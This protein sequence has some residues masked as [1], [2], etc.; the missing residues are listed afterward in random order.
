[1]FCHT[2][3]LNGFAS[4]RALINIH[5]YYYYK[6]V[7]IC[8][9]IDIFTSHSLDESLSNYFIYSATDGENSCAMALKFCRN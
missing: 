3:P 6:A 8:V 7:Y 1:M 2:V 5:Y 4:K 9:E